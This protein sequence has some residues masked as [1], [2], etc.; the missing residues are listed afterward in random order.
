MLSLGI[1]PVEVLESGSW[2]LA[3]FGVWETVF[4]RGLNVGGAGIKCGRTAWKDIQG[5][6]WEFPDREEVHGLEHLYMQN[7]NFMN[8]LF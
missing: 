2:P 1:L 6:I 4:E 5:E 8:V 7:V 3:Q